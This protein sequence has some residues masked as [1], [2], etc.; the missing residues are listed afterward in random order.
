[1]A[2]STGS[3]PRFKWI[4]IAGLAVLSAWCI[5]GAISNS[6]NPGNYYQY[7]HSA[8]GFV[9]P[10]REVLSWVLVITAEAVLA[11][12]WLLAT[13]APRH[14]SV[15]IGL[16]FGVAGFFFAAISMHAPP[17]FANHAIFLLFAAAWLWLAAIAGA[18]RRWLARL[19][20]RG[21]APATEP[22]P[23]SPLPVAVARKPPPPR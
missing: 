14:A 15:V 7:R 19:A 23:P 4:V 21:D 20:S 8:E 16:A 11:T 12:I 3:Q 17:Y 13:R 9:Y 5:A 22:P 2:S 10:A 18:L 1:M 6:A